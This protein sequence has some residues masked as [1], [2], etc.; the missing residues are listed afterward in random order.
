MDPISVMVRK[1][2]DNTNLGVYILDRN[3]LGGIFK[4]KF[5]NHP[6]YENNY[7][8]VYW[9]YDKDEI[10]YI[11][12]SENLLSRIKQHATTKKVWDK[13]K[14]MVIEDKKIA[15]GVEKTL[16]LN[17]ITR[18]NSSTH[19]MVYE[20]RISR[21][22]QIVIHQYNNFKVYVNRVIW[23]YKYYKDCDRDVL[24]KSGA[25]IVY[26]LDRIDMYRGYINLSYKE[27]EDNFKL[28]LK[29]EKHDMFMI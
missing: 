24:M 3:K 10:V 15:R 19:K 6:A 17:F 18:Y 13:A 25:C 5:S 9:L 20:D 22:E 23:W 8:G 21:G 28:R 14:T 7:C 12:F 4:E 1:L 2:M 26:A 27:Y 29:G 11:G 16:L